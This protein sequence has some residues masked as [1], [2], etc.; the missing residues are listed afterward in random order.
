[1]DKLGTPWDDEIEGWLSE[2]KRDRVEIQIV[3]NVPIVWKS[4][5]HYC[6]ALVSKQKLVFVEGGSRNGILRLLDI[7]LTHA[8]VLPLH[9]QIYAYYDRD[10]ATRDIVLIYIKKEDIQ[11]VAYPGTL[12][13]LLSNPNIA[14]RE[15]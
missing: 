7:P 8:K 10:E 13:E 12:E 5:G 6:W 3:K 4:A 11:K 14:K 15:L 9:H 2:L 1:M